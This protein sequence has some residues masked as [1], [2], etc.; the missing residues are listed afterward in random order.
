MKKM[1]SINQILSSKKRMKIFKIFLCK[2]GIG[3]QPMYLM[4][5]KVNENQFLSSKTCNKNLENHHCKL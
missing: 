1:V 2:S 3:Q 5:K 4:G